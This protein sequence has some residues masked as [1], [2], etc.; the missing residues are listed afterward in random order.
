MIHPTAIIGKEVKLGTNVKIGPYV[1]IDGK[2]SIG[3]NTEIFASSS[4]TGNTNIGENNKIF[5]FCSIGSI[6]QDLK[7]SGEESFVKIGDSNIFREFCTINSGTK[8]GGYETIIGNSSL[9]MTAVHIAH[10]CVIGNNVI[11]ANQATLGGHVT[12]EDNAVIGGLS[13]IHQFCRIGE[14]SMIGGMSAVENDVFPFA[15]AIGNRAKITGLNLIGL[16]RADYKKSDIQS[17]NNFIRDIFSSNQSIQTKINNTNDNGNILINKIT[18]FISVKS[19]RGLCRY[20]K[21]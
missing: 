3:D 1:F 11:M 8:G 20:E 13:A 21:K 9:F 12:V 14:L 6:P 10:D 5:S 16:K 7:Y 18:D 2:V 15:L 19:S 4:I 17:V